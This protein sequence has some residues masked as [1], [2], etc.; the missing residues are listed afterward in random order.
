M[1]K[2]LIRMLVEHLECIR[3]PGGMFSRGS[4]VPGESHKETGVVDLIRKQRSFVQ[5]T[6][7]RLF[8]RDMLGTGK[9]VFR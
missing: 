3:I 4:T 8:T 9:A 7:V 1:I 5:S 6:L 2:N